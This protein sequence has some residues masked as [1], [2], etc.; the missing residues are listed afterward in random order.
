VVRPVLSTKQN[1]KVFIK[2]FQKLEIILLKS[3]RLGVQYGH[4]KIYTEKL[5]SSQVLNWC[6]N[7]V[8]ET[9]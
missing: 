4:I 8:T 6:Q 7:V 5:N 1:N 9:C 3:V 2:G